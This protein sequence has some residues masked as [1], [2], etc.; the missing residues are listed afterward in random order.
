MHS[1]LHV[2]HIVIPYY[3]MSSEHRQVLAILIQSGD[4]ILLSE[5]WEPRSGGNN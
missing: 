3:N 1:E 4:K 5:P 2:E